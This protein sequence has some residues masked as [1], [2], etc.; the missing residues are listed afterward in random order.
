[1]TRGTIGS[2]KYAAA[3]AACSLFAG[4]VAFAQAD[5]EDDAT[6]YQINGTSLRVC[7][8]GAMRGVDVPINAFM[9][10]PLNVS[11]PTLDVANHMTF[12]YDDTSHSVPTCPN[13]TVMTGW[14]RRNNW[15]VCSTVNGGLN[16]SKFVDAGTQEVEPNHQERSFHACLPGTYMVGIEALDDVLICQS[17]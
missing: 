1:M 15:L 17:P 11:N 7:S 10:A 16:G 13:D 3:I 8:S 6:L 9:C 5:F 14:D 2:L 4:S 12:T